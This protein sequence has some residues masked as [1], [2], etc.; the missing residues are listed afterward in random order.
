MRAPVKSATS[1]TR[2]AWSISEAGSL[3]GIS[4]ATVRRRI[5]NGDLPA[6]KIGRRVMILDADLVAFF[7]EPARQNGD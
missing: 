4:H 7:E 5:K 1:I 3:Y 2:R 6:R